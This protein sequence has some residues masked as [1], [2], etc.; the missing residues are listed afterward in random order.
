MT[1]PTSILL[2][3]AGFGTRMAPLTDT[4]PK[5]LIEVAGQ[6]LLDHALQFCDRLRVVINTHYLGHQI[7]DYV[8]QRETLIS[9]ESKAPLETGG[10]LK[11]ALPLL[12]SDP[13]F[14]MNTDAV[15]KGHNP[16]TELMNAWGPSMDALL[17]MI[18]KDR[19]VGHTG[20]GDFD[21]SNDGRLARGTQY[22]YSGVQIIRTDRLA[23]IEEETFT[24]WS[25]WGGML[26]HGTMFGLPYSGRWCDVGRPESIPL[27]ETMLKDRE[28]V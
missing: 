7:H 21:M 9:H 25:L 16:I 24:M 22:I 4:Q 11:Q 27:A 14:T 28:D 8:A 26:A 3:A 5:P 17:L 18:P 19:A 12:G 23:E 1:R 6:P 10:G 20:S 15:W 2:F 13:V